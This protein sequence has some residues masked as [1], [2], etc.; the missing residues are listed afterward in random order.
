VSTR[1]PTAD[2]LEALAMGALESTAKERKTVLKGI[3]GQSYADGSKETFRSPVGSR[4][5]LGEIRRTDPDPEWKITDRAALDEF[6]RA[7]FPGSVV[8]SYDIVDHDAAVEVLLEHKPELLAEVQRIDQ[9]ARDALLAESREKEEAAAPGIE[10]V[11]PPGVM[12][13]APAP[14]A[15]EEFG[16]MVRAGVL[17]WDFRPALPAADEEAAS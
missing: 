3:V 5:K 15:F 7:N 1:E 8:T 6:I 2:E 9:A 14:G 10:L 16:R 13:V 4:R 11:K 17:T 12:T